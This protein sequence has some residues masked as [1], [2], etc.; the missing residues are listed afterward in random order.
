MTWFLALV[1]TI[2]R[3]NESFYMAV[4][5]PYQLSIISALIRKYIENVRCRTISKTSLGFLL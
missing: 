1:I 5:F 4:G 3:T 2:G